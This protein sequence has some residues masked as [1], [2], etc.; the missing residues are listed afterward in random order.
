[1][2]DTPPQVTM[3]VIDKRFSKILSEEGPSR[4]G[5]AIERLA[6]EFGV[7]SERYVPQMPND[8]VLATTLA[9]QNTYTDNSFMEHLK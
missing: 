3:S 6:H 2:R 4:R 1:M 9:H 8:L 5:V 7:N